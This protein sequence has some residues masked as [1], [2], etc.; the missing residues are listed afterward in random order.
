MRRTDRA[1]ELLVTAEPW[2][3]IVLDEAHH[4]RRRGAGAGTGKDKGPNQLL[5]L[6]QGLKNRTQG[7][8]PV[9]Y[10]HLDVY[11]RQVLDEVRRVRQQVVNELIDEVRVGRRR[12]RQIKREDAA[13]QTGL[14]LRLR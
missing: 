12:R 6:M 5:R 3:L 7:L 11:K 14:D 8:V 2:D 10:T 1:K 4:A 9:S 13:R